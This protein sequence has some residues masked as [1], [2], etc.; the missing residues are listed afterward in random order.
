[1]SQVGSLLDSKGYGI[2]MKKSKYRI[3]LSLSLIITKCY[4][5]MYDSSVLIK[6]T[7]DV[8]LN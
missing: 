5:N 8:L 7:R 3:L 2:A 4:P 6:K 1:M